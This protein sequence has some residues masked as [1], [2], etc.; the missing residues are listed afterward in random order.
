METVIGLEIHAQLKTETKLFCGC[1]ADYFGKEPNTN[2][3]PVCLGLP[4]ALPVLN[5]RAVEY[6]LK[7]ALALSCEIPSKSKFDRK[8]Y[9]YPD[10]PKGYQISQYDE[11]LAVD[12]EL[13]VKGE[14]IRIRRIHLEEDAG[15]LIHSSGGSSSLDLNRVGVPL[16]EIVTEPDITTPEQAKD[17]VQELRLILRYLD[18]CSG[19]MEKGSLRCDANLSLRREEGEMG[20]KTEVKN[21][22]SFK[23][24]KEALSYE[25]ERQKELLKSGG[26]IWQQTLGWNQ[27][28]KE[29]VMMRAKEE[30]HD[31]RYFPE[32]DLVPLEI[33]MEKRERVKRTLPELPEEK[34]IRW[35]KQYDLP[36][37]DIDVLIEESTLTR[38]FEE[39]VSIYEDPKT[40]S[41]WIM[42]EIM[43][44]LKL[45]D[46]QL[47]N[48]SPSDLAELLS[49]VDEGKVNQ[50][51]AKEVLEESFK[52]SEKPM[53]IVQKKGLK[54]LSD[55]SEL[56]NIVEEVLEDNNEAVQ[57]YKDGKE[58][59]LGFLIGQVMGKTQG[60]AD[61]GMVRKLL[62]EKLKD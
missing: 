41:N 58:Q 47:E 49:A 16:I 45:S 50:N 1:S 52:T 8:N 9:F 3:C 13:S 40:V 62:K 7:A 14:K 27:D 35:K 38:F 48:V 4:G 24:I 2:T 28:K 10:L 34:R 5:E 31:Y 22:N 36:Q 26:E 11:P 6:G 46:T 57:D 21:M 15:K 59:V 12:G 19:D 42:S 44:I 29:A 33:K 54:Q 20:T 17:F 61:P 43:R 23:A 51:T 37:Y 39:T 53:E 60:K 55:E 30:A 18:V 32:P 25:E 56:D